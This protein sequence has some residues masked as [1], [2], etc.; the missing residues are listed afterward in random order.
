MI[1]ITITS[2]ESLADP[3]FDV[4]HRA[5]REVAENTG[6][7][8]HVKAEFTIAPVR[9]DP[10][11]G[12]TDAI[13]IKDAVEN[14][15]DFPHPLPDYIDEEESAQYVGSGAAVKESL[16]TEIDWS[17]AGHGVLGAILGNGNFAGFTRLTQEEFGEHVGLTYVPRKPE[18]PCTI[19]TSSLVK[20]QAS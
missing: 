20:D 14:M 6:Q 19:T 17:G 13:N 15:S 4:L 2:D 5:C 12:R 8:V 1:T 3:H 10:I 16:T 18:V 7:L 9:L 11:S